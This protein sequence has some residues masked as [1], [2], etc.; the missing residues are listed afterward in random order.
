MCEIA[1]DGQSDMLKRLLQRSRLSVFQKRKTRFQCDEAISLGIIIETVSVVVDIRLNSLQCPIDDKTNV[2]E[3]F[4]Q[5]RSL[6]G[7][8]AQP[9][10]VISAC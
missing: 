8:W 3:H 10:F 6:G 5:S 4:G 9:I 7:V 1:L 2:A